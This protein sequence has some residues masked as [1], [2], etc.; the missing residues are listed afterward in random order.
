MSVP[1]DHA[2]PLIAIAALNSAPGPV[3]QSAPTS[4]A[5][6]QAA[7]TA[8]IRADQPVDL[9]P[10]RRDPTLIDTLADHAP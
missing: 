4:C 2:G 6:L 7:Y 1:T 8:F 9:G 3:A 5:L 10:S